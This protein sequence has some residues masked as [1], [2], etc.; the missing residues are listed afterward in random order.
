MGLEDLTGSKYID[1][2]NASNPDGVEDKVSTADDHIRGLKNVLK[3]TF[4]NV[5]G[6]ILPTQAE[7]NVLDGIDTNITTTDFQKTRYFYIDS[8]HKFHGYSQLVAARTANFTLV[9]SDRGK[10]LDC[11]KSSTLTVSI[12]TNA[13]VALE[14]GFTVTLIQS[15][16]GTVQV[17]PLSGVTLHSVD[18]NTKL[19][20]QWSGATLYKRSTDEWVLVGDLQ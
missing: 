9:D 14:V 16:A 7:M 2:L 18:S 6:A 1:S 10:Q 8:D 5:T 13:A 11:S 3:K 4:P 20:K 12:P 19:R 15:G 17:T